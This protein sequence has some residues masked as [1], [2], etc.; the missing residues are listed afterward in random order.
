MAETATRKMPQRE[1]LNL[2]GDNTEDGTM[3]GT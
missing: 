1:Y 2:A 3:G